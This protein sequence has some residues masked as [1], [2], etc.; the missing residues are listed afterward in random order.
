MEMEGTSHAAIKFASGALGY[1]AGTWGAKG[2]R[3]GYS[4]HAHCTEGMLEANFVQ[5]RLI[6]IVGSEEK[7]L[8]E[9]GGFAKPLANEMEHFIDCVA[10]GSR[11]LTDGRSSLQSLRVIWRL[12]EAER[13]GRVADLRGL[14]LS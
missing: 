5:G 9:Y 4:F 1:H 3:L 10:T 6:A 13:Q 7:I 2:S 12:Y 14:G 8:H 11:P